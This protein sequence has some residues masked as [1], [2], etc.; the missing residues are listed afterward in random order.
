MLAAM[1]D[2]VQEH[3]FEKSGIFG[4]VSKCLGLLV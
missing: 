4:M 1:A 2:L 3:D